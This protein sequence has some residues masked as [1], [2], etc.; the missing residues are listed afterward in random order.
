MEAEMSDFNSGSGYLAVPNEEWRFLVKSASKS[1][2][3]K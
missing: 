3:H 2:Q 1:M